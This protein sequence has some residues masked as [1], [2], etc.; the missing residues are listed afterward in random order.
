M[1]SAK[2]SKRAKHVIVDAFGSKYSCPVFATYAE[3]RHHLDEQFHDDLTRA[4]VVE[5]SR[6]ASP[7][8]GHLRAPRF[9]SSFA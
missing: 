1:S 7:I 6:P 5:V 8:F 4:G 9:R 3:T 2:R